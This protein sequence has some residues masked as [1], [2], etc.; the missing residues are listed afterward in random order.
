MKKVLLFILIFNIFLVSCSKDNSS[1]IMKK[2]EKTL[3]NYIGYETE[4]ELQITMDEK[5]SIYLL[6]EKYKYN[7]ETKVDILELKESK[8]ITIEYKEDKIIINNASLK[9]S[10][11][12]KDI[13]GLNK[14]MLF[15]EVFQEKDF[16][17]S[18]K[19]EKIENKSYYIFKFIPKEKNKYNKEKIIYLD[20]KDFKP[21]KMITMDK[22]DNPRV[23]IKYKNFKYIK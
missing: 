15:G 18:I 12:L 9:Q 17:K 11:S 6:K 20:K 10:I 2:L 19:E 3:D 8:G 16:I 5:E 14:G 4:A 23:I 1:K 21:Y 22:E 7:G 13:K